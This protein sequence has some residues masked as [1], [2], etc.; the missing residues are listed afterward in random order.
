MKTLVSLLLILA[1]TSPAQAKPAD[2]ELCTLELYEESE[3]L[4][5][6]EEVFDIRTATSVSA[7]ELEMLNQHMNYISFEEA[8]TYTFAEI[9]EQFN[10]SSDELYIHKLTSRQTGRVYLEVKSYPGDNPYGLVFDAGTGTLLATN[11]D[12]SYTLI[13]S[14]GTKFSCYELNKGKY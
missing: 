11:G 8:R 12:D 6:A 1:S 10:D 4:F 5:A 7:S 9:Q 13:D 3:A 14:N 2:V